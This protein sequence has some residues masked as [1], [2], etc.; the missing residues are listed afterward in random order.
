[1]PVTLWINKGLRRITLLLV[2][3]GMIV[4][5]ASP[6]AC[7]EFYNNLLK[8]NGQPYE[9]SYLNTGITQDCIAPGETA[10]H[11]QYLPEVRK[12]GNA[13]TELLRLAGG[14]LLC[15]S[16]TILIYCLSLLLLISAAYYAA[17]SYYHIIFIHLQD[18]H[19]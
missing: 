6:S 3:A 16:C 19:K 12:S 13:R 8:L 14:G 9:I 15:S 10:G 18:G 1:M 11:N 2:V 5:L 4:G 7:D 17:L